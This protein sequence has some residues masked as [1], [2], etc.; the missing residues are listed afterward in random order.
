[1][2]SRS[3]ILGACLVLAACCGRRIDPFTASHVDHTV[4]ASKLPLAV[5]PSSVGS[6]PGH[7]KS[8]AGYFYD[9][10]LEY[11]VWMHPEKGAKPRAGDQDYFAAFAQYERALAFARREPG[12]EQPLVL[13][14]QRESINEPTPGNYQWVRTERVTEW[15]TEW[16]AGSRRTTTS[17][18]QFLDSH[19]HAT[20]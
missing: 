4:A 10:V 15:K 17:I 18:P 3:V 12:A 5:S 19:R 1:M 11:R 6:Y 2:N 16:L 9:E 7:T 8:G 20:K 13:V 14:R